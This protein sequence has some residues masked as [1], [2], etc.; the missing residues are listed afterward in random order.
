MTTLPGPK[1]RIL[2]LPLAALWV[3]GATAATVATQDGSKVPDI[4]PLPPVA[5][6]PEN[7]PNEA[8]IALGR[9]LF[10]DN[11]ISASGT[12]NC[13]TCHLPRQGWTVQTPLSPANPGRVE[14]RNSPTLINVGYNKALIWDGRAWPLE[15]QAIG[16]TKNPLHKGQDIDKLMAVLEADPK[17][18][19]MFKDAYGSAPNPKDYGKALAVFQRHFIVTGPS[20]FDRYME[21]DSSAM[22]AVAVRGMAVF[23]GKGN[24]IACHN[25]PNFTDSGFYN[26]GLKHNPILDDEA[27][28]Q[29]LKFDAKRTKN[30]DW[31]TITTDPGRYLIT[32]DG[33]DW[34]RFK[35]PTLRNLADTPP[36]MHD[37]RYRTLDEV[38]EHYNRGGDGVRNQDP[39]IKPLDLSDSE[40]QD[41]KAFLMALRGPLPE[42]R[43]ED[44][45][46][47]VNAA[48]GQDGKALF[49]GKA[50]CINC[51]QADGKGVPGVFPPLAGNPRVVE[52]D[53]S[54]VAQTII[55]GRKGEI[56]VHDK[57][58]NAI[59][60]PIGTQQGLSDAEIAAVASYVR[61]AWGNKAPPVTAEV[62]RQQR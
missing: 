10:F 37:G 7:Q 58:F 45:V 28:Q 62:V 8:R 42:I 54:F 44:W 50:T 29:V 56:T 11:R 15:K 51:H 35:T 12:M 57:V 59:M 47:P 32:H 26:V 13:A 18:V 55:H 22:D 60:P 61:N 31:E 16:S 23:K 1:T 27:H 38:I 43:M 3:F 40:K 20:P 5:A 41:L 49:Q 48:A 4:G 19:K 33:A 17:M 46:R 25:G 52:G 39:R 14:R 6:N 24:C 30:A 36:Y 9:A 53:G 34:G 21:G 2:L